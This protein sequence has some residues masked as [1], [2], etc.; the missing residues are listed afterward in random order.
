MVSGKPS[1]VGEILAI[2]S[3]FL[4]ASSDVATH[5][6]LSQKRETHSA[7]LR[8]PSGIRLP[9]TWHA[10]KSSFTSAS[11]LI[12]IILP[13]AF[14]RERDTWHTTWLA[15]MEE[16]VVQKSLEN[17]QKTIWIKKNVLFC[18]LALPTCIIWDDP[19]DHCMDI[20]WHPAPYN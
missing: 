12:Y 11:D 4:R 19:I 1:G 17:T 2:W 14:P 20:T 16:A 6:Y 8:L 13:G 10:Q 3:L 18:F 15:T 7:Y 9:L 5:V